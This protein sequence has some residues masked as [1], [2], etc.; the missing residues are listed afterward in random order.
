[1]N[2]KKGAKRL[3]QW[4]QQPRKNASKDNA[5]NNTKKEKQISQESI[6]FTSDSNPACQAKSGIE[7]NFQLVFDGLMTKLHY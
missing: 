1:M 6:I 3:P 2:N 4:S 5:T 7:I